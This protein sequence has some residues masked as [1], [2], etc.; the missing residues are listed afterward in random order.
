MSKSKFPQ[1]LHDFEKSNGFDTVFN[2]VGPSL[3]R[4]EFAEECDINSLMRRYEAAGATI[5]GLPPMQGEPRYV[6]FTEVPNNLLDYLELVK[7]A[8][9]AFMTLPAGVRR[10]FDNSATDFVDFASDPENLDQMRAWGLAPPAKPVAPPAMP[11]A[12]SAKP[13]EPPVGAGSAP[14]AP[15]AAAPPAPS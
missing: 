1:A 13:Q 15:P 2:T 5:N 7:N 11:L 8:E 6:D 14:S 12:T 4:Q 9:R 10:E 3:A